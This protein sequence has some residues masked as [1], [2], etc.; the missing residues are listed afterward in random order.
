MQ[1][2]ERAAERDYTY[3]AFVSYSHR[4]AKW[5]E[6]IQRAIEH[7]KLP[8]VIRKEAQK[9]LPK[10]IAPVFRDAT[11]LGVDVLVDGLHAEL[12]GSRYLIVVCSP[13]AA[14]PN[15]EGK[16]FVDE[17]VRRFCELGRAK[18]IIPVIV[19]RRR[20]VQPPREQEGR[21]RAAVRIY[22]A[23]HAQ[24]RVRGSRWAPD[25]RSARLDGVH[26]FVRRVR[27]QHGVVVF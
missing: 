7:Y 24:G 6:W 10:R 17:E 12:E 16:S 8:A 20:R 9:P 4:D 23:Q 19:E 5:A 2:D 13:N 25:D 21:R 18:R 22:G 14:K 26:R 27:Q 1:S 15:A 3:Y 11:D